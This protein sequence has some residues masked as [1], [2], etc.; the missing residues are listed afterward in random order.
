MESWYSVEIETWGS[1]PAP[2]MLEELAPTLELVGA[3]AAI[4]SAGGLGGGPGTTFSIATPDA[5]PAYAAKR[6]LEIF[7]DA[8]EKI[9]VQYAAIARVALTDERYLERWLE[10]GEDEYVG[11]SEVAEILRVSKQR[12]SELRE[13]P[14][15]PMPVAELAAGP[16]WK[17]SSLKRFIAEW[18]RKPGRPRKAEAG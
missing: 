11:V 3:H 2:E 6:A 10:Q 5:D 15:F 9:G 4:A 8:C 7:H 16:V 17:L 12:V 1:I 13:K 18:P 14:T